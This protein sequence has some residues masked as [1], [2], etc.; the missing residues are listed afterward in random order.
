[1]AFGTSAEEPLAANEGAV[2]VDN[3]VRASPRGNAVYH[4]R[5]DDGALEFFRRVVH[6][7]TVDIWGS[8]FWAGNTV[9]LGDGGKCGGNRDK[10]LGSG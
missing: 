9:G 4:V 1:M 5:T 8:L 6:W 10:L 3:G 2:S 7:H